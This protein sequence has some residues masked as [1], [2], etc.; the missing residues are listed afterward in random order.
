MIIDAI[1]IKINKTKDY[2]AMV[3]AITNDKCFSFFARGILKITSKNAPALNLFNLVKLNLNEGKQGGLSLKEAKLIKSYSHILDDFNKAAALNYFSELLSKLVIDEENINLFPFI[4][5]ILEKLDSGFDPLTLIN[6]LT[7][8]TLN[9]VGVG[10]NVNECIHCHS[11][12][13]IVKMDFNNGGFVC[14]KCFNNLTK[15]TPVTLLRLYRYIFNISV[16]NFIDK[17]ID[18]EN[19]KIIFRNLI[20]YIEESLSTQI[21]TKSLVKLI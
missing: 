19:N 2:D 13:G 1:I 4:E 15:P 10:L 12:K 6:L 3:K 7:A 5:F 9:E 16:D 11:D 14:K 8:K 21:K 20:E 17:P 18:R